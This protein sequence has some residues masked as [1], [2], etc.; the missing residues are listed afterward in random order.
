[1]AAHSKAIP[2]H[3]CRQCGGKAHREVFNTRNA[4]QGFYCTRHATDAVRD[5]DRLEQ[6]ISPLNESTKTIPG[7][8]GWDSP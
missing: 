4:S 7:T 3:R 8:M 6:A 5:L 1:M 2:N